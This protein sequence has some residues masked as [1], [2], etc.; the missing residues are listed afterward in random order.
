MDTQQG[1]TKKQ[2][3][4]DLISLHYYSY[5]LLIRDIK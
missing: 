4:K 2:I 1:E 3:T 5:I